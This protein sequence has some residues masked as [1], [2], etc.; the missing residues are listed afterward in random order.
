MEPLKRMIEDYTLTGRKKELMCWLVAQ[1][2]EHF[3]GTAMGMSLVAQMRTKIVFPDS[4]HSADA[5]RKLEISDPA[6]RM[7]KTDMTL[8][9][10]RRFLLWRQEPVVCEFDLSELPQLPL[11]AG[12]AG[13]IRL[14]ERIRAEV[15]QADVL[16][17]FYRRLDNIRRAA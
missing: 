13:T 3:T 11:L 1:Q 7:L 4:N 9:K 5:L 12:R 17:E 15:G 10:A 16:E 2:P 8:G 6:I 14:M